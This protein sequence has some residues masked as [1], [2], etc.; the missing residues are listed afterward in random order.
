MK[1]IY[2]ILAIIASVNIGVAVLITACKIEEA[3][4]DS[5]KYGVAAYCAFTV[6]GICAFVE[7]IQL[8]QGG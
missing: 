6:I 1:I 8:M 3:E 7:L 5:K 2:L 4:S